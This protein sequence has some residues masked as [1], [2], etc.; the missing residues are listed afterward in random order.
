MLSINLK[1]E[2]KVICKAELIQIEQSAYNTDVSIIRLKHND[3][4]KFDK[5]LEK[6][7]II[8]ILMNTQKYGM[9]IYMKG[10]IYPNT[11]IENNGY[12]EI[13]GEFIVSDDY[14]PYDQ[15]LINHIYTHWKDSPVSLVDRSGFSEKD[16]CLYLDTLAIFHNFPERLQLKSSYVFD[17]NTIVNKCD[18]FI[19]LGELFAGQQIYFCHGLDVLEKSLRHHFKSL[20][21]KIPFELRN[22]NLIIQ[23]VGKDYFETMLEVMSPFFDLKLN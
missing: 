7:L 23:K 5:N 6:K 15:E 16:F 2:N 19:Q 11:L 9:V 4:F 13:T 22:K 18:L 10:I 14:N 20:S 8:D 3:L 17:S 1:K 21:S 12:L